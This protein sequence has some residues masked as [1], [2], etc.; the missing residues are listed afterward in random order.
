MKLL[1][2]VGVRGSSE[3]VMLTKKEFVT[4]MVAKGLDVANVTLVGILNA[5]SG[6]HFPEPKAFERSFQLLTQVAGRA[7]RGTKPGRVILQT[8][9]PEHRVIEQAKHHHFLGFY[10][11]ELALRR[12]YS[13]PPFSQLLRLMVSAPEVERAQHFSKSLCHHLKALLA[14]KGW[15]SLAE[16]EVLG[17]S[18]CL[19]EKVQDRYRYHVLVKNKVGPALQEAL[20]A[21]VQGLAVPSG[22]HLLWDVDAQSLL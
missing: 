3:K 22:L 19:I 2:A 17:P 11:D 15:G 1:T 10:T 13:F 6:L 5:D 9:S 20:L 12:D 14:E 8:W 21:W 7:G 18:P 16:A 4:Q